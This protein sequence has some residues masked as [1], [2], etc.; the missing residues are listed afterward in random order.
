M[1]GYF[2]NDSCLS[3]INSLLKSFEESDTELSGI[4]DRVI[5]HLAADM[6][7]VRKCRQ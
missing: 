1:Y 3:A 5:A 7:E 4:F 2:L 6:S